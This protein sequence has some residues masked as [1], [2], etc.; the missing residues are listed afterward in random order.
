MSSRMFGNKNPQWKGGID[1][2]YCW[3]IAKENLNKVCI[4]GDTLKLEVHHK[5]LNIKNN[6]LENL[7]YLCKRCHEDVHMQIRRKKNPKH[8]FRQKINNPNLS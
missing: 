1:R 6:K 2:E 4:C 8:K 5:D 7:I 3:R